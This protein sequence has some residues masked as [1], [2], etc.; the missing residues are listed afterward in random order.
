MATRTGQS[1]ASGTHL[2]DAQRPKPGNLAVRGCW[3]LIIKLLIL[4]V[5]IFIWLLLWRRDGGLGT[6]SW[7]AFILLVLLLLILIWIQGHL[8]R[9][10]CELVQPSACKHGDPGLL[11]GRVL[12]RIKGTAGGMGISHYEL[13]LLYGGAPI[14]G[15]IVYADAGGN[16]DLA[17][18]QGN[19]QVSGG[20]LGFVDIKAAVLGAGA[21]FVT[22]S[23][24]QVRM[25][26]VGLGGSSHTCLIDF[27]I[28]SARCVIKKVGAAWAHDSLNPDEALCEV[29]PPSAHAL[30]PA[31]VGGS[32][33]VRGAANVYGC[34]AELISELHM[35]AIPDAGFSFAQPA[36]GTPIPVPAGVKISEAVFTTADQRNNN[37]LDGLSSEGN[38]L[39]FAPGW[40]V[41][42]EW[43]IADTFI[44]IPIIVPDLV[45][46]YWGTLAS[47]RYTLLLAVKDTA[48]NTFYDIQ[49]V[50][51]DNDGT[52]QLITSIG[53][54]AP[55][56]DL[57]LSA[58][59]SGTCPI[60]GFAWD[61]PIDP[62]QPQAAPNDNFGGYG[63]SFQKNGGGS[64]SIPVLTPGVRVPNDWP[65]LGVAD[66]VL[67]EWDI[68]SAL[69][70]G[71]SV[72]A[73]SEK[74]A[75]GT[76]C[77][78]VIA[79]GVNDRTLVGEGGSNHGGTHLYAL[80]IINDL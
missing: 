9:L 24:F 38:I 29:G 8:V 6:T 41:R 1:Y 40:N 30:V 27:Q 44:I 7:I 60:R 56:E 78:Y 49:R 67:A 33:F 34:A 43:V 79:L 10:T 28:A 76:R 63:M 70:G 71:S 13:E 5:I 36:N 37:P 75:R 32:I 52:T 80:N 54:L 46:Q 16:P 35:W 26:V 50:W 66:G 39:T 59:K 21:G 48:G 17:A 72:P 14:A 57:K 11:P 4:L 77:A 74:L 69:D 19:F 51:V 65:T 64:G 20:T 2:E 22:N 42:T 3:E 61:P 18:T 58:F 73:G 62:A 12:E 53:G 31:S 55:C 25:R 68:V 45:E 23:N 15:G 47:G